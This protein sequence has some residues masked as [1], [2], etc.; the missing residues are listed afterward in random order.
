MSEVLAPPLK[1]IEPAFK[2]GFS[3]MTRDPVELG[4]LLTARATLIKS[5][6]SDMPADH[7]KFLIS[8]ERGEPDWDLL[9][10]PNAAELPAVRW[11]QQNLDKLSANKRAVLVA[12]LEEV[13]ADP[14][15]EPSQTTPPT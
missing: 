10:V 14:G 3:G 9:G 6:V 7:R 13:L 15:T 11:R 12:R 5:I 2:H 8:F 1:N 4:D